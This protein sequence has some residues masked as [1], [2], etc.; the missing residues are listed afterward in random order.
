MKLIDVFKARE[1]LKRLTESRFN[2]YKVLRKLV[3]AQRAVDAEMEFYATAEKKAIDLYAEK[4][5]KGNPVILA[6][7]RLKLKDMEAK[8]A[9]DKEIAKLNDTEVDDIDTIVIREGD[10]VSPGD[11]PTPSDMALLECIIAFED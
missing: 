1:P 4:D 5:E 6:D 7:D 3:K 2:N 9:F 8:T 10:F 11:Y